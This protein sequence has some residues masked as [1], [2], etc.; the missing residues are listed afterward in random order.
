MTGLGM[1]THA[2]HDVLDRE[3]KTQY[4]QDVTWDIQRELRHRNSHALLTRVHTG[5]KEFTL[6]I[7]YQP[8]GM[9]A[10]GWDVVRE[11][12][13]CR[14]AYELELNDSHFFKVSPEFHREN[15]QLL[16][17]EYVPGSQ[18]LHEIWK[19][20]L[21]WITPGGDFASTLKYSGYTARWINAFSENGKRKFARPLTRETLTEF[22]QE[23]YNECFGNSLDGRK[24]FF[25]R[26][27]SFADLEKQLQSLGPQDLVEIPCHGDLGPHNV[28]IDQT[29]RLNVIDV[30]MSFENHPLYYED[31]VN[32]LM[33][34]EEMALN[35]MYSSDRLR[36]LSVL[37]L[38]SLLLSS[39]EEI[40]LF[41]IT[42]IKRT[43]THA[44][45]YHHPKRR[46]QSMFR[47]WV[48]ER[49]CRQALKRIP[50]LLKTESNENLSET[51]YP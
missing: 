2:I 44:A 22:L 9:V 49:W 50:G 4:G 19:K 39:P 6:F 1:E 10:A 7:K 26:A 23:R 11:F 51:L 29:K 34:L 48:Y 16:A 21:L 3:M 42:F 40:R 30:G 32:F 20:A 35:P 8:E 46:K 18:P 17:L 36:A 47:E 38:E 41:T 43:L 31:S 27:F 33:Y 5:E 15:P 25:S 45:F 14:A 13:G 28:L 37:F 12:E 24:N